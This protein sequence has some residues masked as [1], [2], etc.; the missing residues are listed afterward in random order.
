MRQ[1][2]AERAA[3]GRE[4]LLARIKEQ[5]PEWGGEEYEPWVE[6]KLQVS[7][8]F[9]TAARGPERPDWRELLP[10]IACPVLL[11][12]ADPERGAIVTPEIAAEAQRLLPGLQV[13][14]VRGAGH[15][16][17]REQ[18]DAYLRAVRA[19]LDTL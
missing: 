3:L 10:R 14:R 18:F 6:S 17:R 12:T 9:S 11:I 16:V 15:S 8:R 5:H 1:E 7:E 19:F 2:A 13:V 4:G